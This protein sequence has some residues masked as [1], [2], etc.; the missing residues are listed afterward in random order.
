MRPPS[1][2]SLL[3]YKAGVPTSERSFDGDFFIILGENM[4]D[5]VV[6][7][8][9]AAPYAPTEAIDYEW[10]HADASRYASEYISSSFMESLSRIVTKPYLRDY[11]H[12]VHSEAS[13]H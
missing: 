4:A 5:E 12:Q 13:L 7:T 11:V 1:S 2:S 9:L 8:Q 6:S 3:P 10:A